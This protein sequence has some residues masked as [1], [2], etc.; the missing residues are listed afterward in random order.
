MD[1]PTS[2]PPTDN[3]CLWTWDGK[4]W[5]LTKGCTT[6][7]CPTPDPLPEGKGTVGQTTTTACS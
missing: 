7:S 5:V 4:E 3:V 6:G 2:T 1:N